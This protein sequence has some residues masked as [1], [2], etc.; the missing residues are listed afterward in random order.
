[1][2]AVEPAICF[3]R[4][5]PWAIGPGPSEIVSLDQALVAVRRWLDLMPRDPRF[6]AQR[7]RMLTL[8]EILRAARRDP[9]PA[10]LAS[11]TLGIEGMVTFVQS[12]EAGVSHLRLVHSA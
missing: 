3:A 10:D 7:E 5:L 8:R 6:S 1:M 9:T 11:A 2:V 12:T 4:P